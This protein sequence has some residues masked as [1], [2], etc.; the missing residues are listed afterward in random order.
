MGPC[1]FGV[2]LGVYILTDVHYYFRTI[3]TYLYAKFFRQRIKITDP[4]EIYGT[5]QVNILYNL[6]QL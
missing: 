1:L 4:S 5:V 3:Y 2:V 6:S